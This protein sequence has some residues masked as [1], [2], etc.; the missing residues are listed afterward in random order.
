[1]PFVVNMKEVIIV[2]GVETNGTKLLTDILIKGGFFGSN[3]HSQQLDKILKNQKMPD[4]VKNIT[5]KR[6]VIRR[7]LP[8]DGKMIGLQSM[9]TSFK[10]LGYK[11]FTVL[12]IIR[13]WNWVVQ[14]QTNKKHRPPHGANFEWQHQPRDDVIRYSYN[15]LF[16]E[17]IN[18]DIPFYFITYESLIYETEQIFY[19]LEKEFNLDSINVDIF[20]GNE[21]YFHRVL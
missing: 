19:W 1:M 12:V 9:I 2:L 10:S 4:D 7:S 8:H 16:K 20:N 3:G 21:K 11:K 14:S 5:L 18:I 17:L 6:L 13:N 15:H